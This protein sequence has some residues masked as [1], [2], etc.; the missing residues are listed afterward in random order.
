[1]R[2]KSPDGAKTVN[3]L[4]VD[5]EPTPFWTGENEAEEIEAWKQRR[6]FVWDPKVHGTV[7]PAGRRNNGSSGLTLDERYLRPLAIERSDAWITDCLDTYRMSE[8]VKAAIEDRFGPFAS[9]AGLAE[10]RLESHPNEQAIV[11]EALAEQ[12]RR[13]TDELASARPETIVTLGNAAR[14]VFARLVEHQ[15]PTRGLVPTGYGEKVQLGEKINASW[16]PLAHPGVLNAR[17]QKWTDAHEK[18]E[19]STKAS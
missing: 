16:Y 6:T 9:S 18:W 8:G 11:R 12:A 14:T 5:N 1:V 13:L 19:K 15:L 17:N 7:A 2:W 3:A 4:P 10:P